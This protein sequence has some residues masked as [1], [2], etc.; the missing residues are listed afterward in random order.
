MAT[1][2]ESVEKDL[3]DALEM[4]NFRHTLRQHDRS[5]QMIFG[6]GHTV[7]SCFNCDNSL[8]ACSAGEANCNPKLARRVASLRDFR[9]V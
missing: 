3:W 6:T 2:A 5:A 7:N 1:Q 9:V 4:D 8:R